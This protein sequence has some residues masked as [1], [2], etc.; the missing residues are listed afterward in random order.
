MK[1]GM[2]RELRH[3]LLI[4]DEVHNIRTLPQ[5]DKKKGINTYYIGNAMYYADKT[6][7]LTGTPLINSREEIRCIYYLLNPE[8]SIKEIKGLTM[9]EIMEGLRCKISY[10]EPS[11]QRDYPE[12]REEDVTIVMS[13]EFQKDYEEMVLNIGESGFDSRKIDVFGEKNLSVFYNGV[14]RA[15]NVL[16]EKR[17]ER[18][19]KLQWIFRELRKKEG[20]KTVIFSH[21]KEAG[22]LLVAKQLRPDR[23]GMITGEVSLVRRKRTIEDYNSGK[24]DILLITKAA[25]E[26]IHL[27]GTRNVILM[28]PGWNDSS[29]EQVIARA[30]RY[31]SHAHLPVQERK[32][33]VYHLYHLKRT[34]VPVFQRFSKKKSVRSRQRS[35]REQR[36]SWPSSFSEWIQTQTENDINIRQNSIDLLLFLIKHYKELSLQPML[37]EM[38]RVSIE[39]LPC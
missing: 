28:E 6:L 9:E 17:F 36:E 11:S 37:D 23:Y 2:E 14:R 10:Y 30:I 5:I 38:R 29:M 25:G 19:R 16:E 3:S 12:R 24:I 31:K 15:V 32:V 7:V 4:M 35:T 22:I 26:G 13:E 33:T 1:Q 39:S 18:N 20:E 34:D 8:R 27:K 21:F